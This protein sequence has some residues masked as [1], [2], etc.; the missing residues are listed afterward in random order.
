MPTPR[1]QLIAD[2]RKR[3]AAASEAPQ[4]PTSRA[5]WLARLRRRL[6]QFL[7]SLYGEGDWNAP[8][9]TVEQVR[10]ESSSVRRGSPD[11]AAAPTEGLPLDLAGKPAKDATVIRAVLESV[12]G[13][14][15]N[16]PPTGPLAAGI[17]RDDWIVVASISRGL[18]PELTAAA[19]LSKGIVPRVIPHRRDVTVEVRAC[20]LAAAKELIDSQRHHLFVRPRPEPELVGR[21]ATIATGGFPWPV[22]FLG[23]GA[24]P[25]VGFFAVLLRGLAQPGGLDPSVAQHF[26]W[27]VAYIW[28]G[29][30]GLI[31]VM[32][33]VVGL[34]RKSRPRSSR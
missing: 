2:W 4:E 13:A 28:L 15:E 21:P 5:V 12:A 1:D 22:L 27:V 17:D 7:L 31:G 16:R 19:L 11:R 10:G 24:G 26:L 30:F 3:L 34:R 18:D 6:Y 14:S 20:H 23:L 25:V 9:G 29:S 32:Y 8:V 33:L